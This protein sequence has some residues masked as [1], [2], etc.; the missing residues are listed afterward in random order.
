VAVRATKR[1]KRQ[2]EDLLKDSEF[3]LNIYREVWCV[4]SILYNKKQCQVKIHRQI[5]SAHRAGGSPAKPLGDA[6]VVE[7]MAIV[8]HFH[9]MAGCRIRCLILQADATVLTPCWHRLCVCA[10]HQEHLGRDELQLFIDPKLKRCVGDVAV[11]VGLM[12]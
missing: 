6:L 12:H 7:C 9:T 4:T 3:W 1:R 10:E 2:S 8:G 5:S 11:T